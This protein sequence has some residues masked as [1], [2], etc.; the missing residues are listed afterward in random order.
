LRGGGNDEASLLE[1]LAYMEFYGRML[2]IYLAH[3]T[4]K[5]RLKAPAHA[6]I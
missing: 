4:S 3:P 5:R 6:S 2:R 1:C